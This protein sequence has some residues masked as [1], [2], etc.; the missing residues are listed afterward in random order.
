[1]NYRTARIV[2]NWERTGSSEVVLRVVLDIFLLLPALSLQAACSMGFWKA[3]GAN[4]IIY[5]V[6]GTP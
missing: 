1:M 3:K 5:G 2:M 6:F 4:D